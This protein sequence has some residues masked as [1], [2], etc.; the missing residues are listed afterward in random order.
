MASI[1]ATFDVLR[2]VDDHSI[3]TASQQPHGYMYS[4]LFFDTEERQRQ[5]GNNLKVGLEF[6]FI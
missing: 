6:A 4:S 3:K 5:D 1:R 2:D